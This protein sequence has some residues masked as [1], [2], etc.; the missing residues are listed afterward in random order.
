MFAHNH[1]HKEE[2]KASGA[3]E[4]DKAA[5]QN[6]VPQKK[7]DPL[8]DK[9]I[10]IK[11]SEFQKLTREAADYKDKYVRLFAEFDNVRKR[12]DREKL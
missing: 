4:S 2:Q 6:Q 5:L 3:D 12:M 8:P 10:P 9:L 1:K 7:E 11:E